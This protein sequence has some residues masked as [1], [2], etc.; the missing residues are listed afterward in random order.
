MSLLTLVFW[1]FDVE[2]IRRAVTMRRYNKWWRWLQL[3]FQEGWRGLR[4]SFDELVPLITQEI[5]FKYFYA[6]AFRRRRHYV[7]GLS[8]RPSVRSPKY[9]LSTCTWVRWSIRPT[10]TVLRHVR[11]SVRPSGEVSGHLPE[12]TWREWAEIL[13]A[14]VSWPPSELISSWLRFVDF[15]N[16]GTI[17]T[18]WIESNLGFPAISW[19]THGGNGPKYCML[20][21]LDHLQNWLD[22]GHSLLIFLLLAPLWLSETGQIWGF[23]SFPRECMEGMAWNCMLMYLYHLQNWLVYG[24]GLLIFQILMLFWLSETCKIWGFRAFPAERMEGMAWNF[25]FCCI[26]TTF[27]TD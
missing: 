12:N 6:S 3:M 24:L 13:H 7:F 17:L 4:D 16:F 18:Q 5:C 15:S 22:Y 9:P 2:N 19:R 20:M 14:D 21:Y 10:V 11:P 23:R 27:R 25:A 26:L 8:V 1:L